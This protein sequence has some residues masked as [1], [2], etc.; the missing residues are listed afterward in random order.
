VDLFDFTELMTKFAK[1]VAKKE[2]K[3]EGGYKRDI[4]NTLHG[5][6]DY[7]TAANIRNKIKHLLFLAFKFS[8]CFEIYGN[9]GFEKMNVSNF[10]KCLVV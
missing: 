9:H 8:E 6:H 3:S 1:K 4:D 10:L 7:L 2:S 5:L